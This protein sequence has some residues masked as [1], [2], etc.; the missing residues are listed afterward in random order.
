MQLKQLCRN[1]RFILLIYVTSRIPSLSLNKQFCI[2]SFKIQEGLPIEKY[3]VVYFVVCK[4]QYS[5]HGYFVVCKIQYSK[6][7]STNP[8]LLLVEKLTLVPT[9]VPFTK[10]PQTDL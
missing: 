4:I 10:E 9:P 5:K 8:F 1:L 2:Q 3:N 6:H 7:G